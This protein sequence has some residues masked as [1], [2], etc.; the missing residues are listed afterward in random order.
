MATK[1]DLVEAH[2][3]SR[4]RLV[5]AFVSGA[6]GGRE[7]EPTRP[8]R[9]V[10]GGIALAILLVAGAA[11]ASI[12][13]PKAPSD[14]TD[15]GLVVSKERGAAY[16][17]LDGGD[18][19]VLRPVINVTSAQLILGADPEPSVVKQSEIDKYTI[20]EDIGI[21]NAPATVPD[22]D[23]L[24][25]S[26]WT[27][28]TADGSGIKVDVSEEQ[29]VEPLD[30]AGMLV[31]A[32]GRIYLI[33]ESA[34]PE[35][36]GGT[37]A[38]S[39][40]V[41]DRGAVD[42]MLQQLGMPIRSE[43]VEV[44]E[45]WLTL[46]PAGGALSFGSFGLAGYGEPS[47][48]AG[49]DGLPSGARVGDRYESAGI[50]LLVTRTAPVAL[51]PFAAAVYASAEKPAGYEPRTLTPEGDPQLRQEVPA[52]EEARWPEAGLDKV[53]GEHCAVLLPDPAGGAPIVKLA[54]APVGDASVLEADTDRGTVDRTV[55]AG[56]GAYALSAG[57]DDR[58]VG[59]PYFVDA[60]GVAYALVGD[61][62]AERLGY[63]DVD[64][65]IVPDPWIELFE[66]GVPLSVNAALCPPDR[67]G[68]SSTCE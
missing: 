7:V 10:I 44:P 68:R 8:G 53:T 3:F 39:Y 23:L 17:I 62:A 34:E 45:Q 37:R 52:Y 26:G 50:E 56:R 48:I 19:P 46:F 36:G 64:A 38:Y 63:G 47:E 67:P 41:P 27:A 59:T 42:L 12:L 58:R 21:L 16:V 60:K 14:W 35:P 2:A 4:R 28:C 15:G 22:D 30:G 5:T 49:Q 57:W 9:T 31:R 43:A 40:L 18:D 29:L 1:K 54:T 51:T 66:E 65:P 11:I 32:R 61:Q 24:L 6:P 20:G 55:D 25:E 13:S 33:A